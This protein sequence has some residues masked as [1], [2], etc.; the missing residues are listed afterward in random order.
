MKILSV[1][2]LSELGY[3]SRLPNNPL[4]KVYFS[5]DKESW[6]IVDLDTNY[7]SVNTMINQ[8]Y[9]PKELF[10]GIIES[11]EELEEILKQL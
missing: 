2:Y 5:E 7:V 4:Y 8:P 6:L 9:K 10:R 1:E 3:K 11:R